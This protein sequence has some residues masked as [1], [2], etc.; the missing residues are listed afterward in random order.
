MSAP[1]PAAG[2]FR[3]RVRAFVPRYAGALA[4]AGWT[5]PPAAYGGFCAG[6]FADDR[7]VGYGV[8]WGLTALSAAV[9]W[10]LAGRATSRRA[11]GRAV[12]IGLLVAAA[13]SPL[14]ARVWRERNHG[15]FV[16]DPLPHRLMGLGWAGPTWGGVALACGGAWGR[17]VAGGG[18]APDDDSPA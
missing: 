2:P 8:G 17:W 3:A 5:G 12:L 9:G 1:A 14:A 11:C 10:R 15:S 18:A 7:F 13:A 16:L 6:A 4:A